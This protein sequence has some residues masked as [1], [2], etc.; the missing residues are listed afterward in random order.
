[1]FLFLVVE[2]RYNVSIE[3]CRSER[4]RLA[5]TFM[6]PQPPNIDL[7]DKQHGRPPW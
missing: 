3:T 6:H 5:I 4:G 1:M 2:C 7:V